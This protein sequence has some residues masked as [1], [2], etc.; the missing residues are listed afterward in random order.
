MILD[1]AFSTVGFVTEQM[2]KAINTSDNFKGSLEPFGRFF[3]IGSI[4]V[5]G[6]K[7]MR[8]GILAKSFI[9]LIIIAET[10]DNSSDSFPVMIFLFGNLI[11]TICLFSFSFLALLLELLAGVVVLLAVELDWAGFAVLVAGLLAVL[12]ELEAGLAVVGVVLLEVVAGF[13]VLE[14]VV[15]LAVELD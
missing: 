9:A 7:L 5:G 11:A 14:L 15:L 10:G 12:L 6:S 4:K 3:K 1:N 8:S 13:P 2:L